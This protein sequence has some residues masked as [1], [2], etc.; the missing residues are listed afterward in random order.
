[1]YLAI[2]YDYHTTCIWE[3]RQ[4]VHI[5]R[6]SGTALKL[7]LRKLQHSNAISYFVWNFP[8]NL[9]SNNAGKVVPCSLSRER[10]ALPKVG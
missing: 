6:S 10:Q 7:E 4:H 2:K 1:M 9:N 8:H 3:I 5:D